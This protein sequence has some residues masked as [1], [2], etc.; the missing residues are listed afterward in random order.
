MR[1]LLCSTFATENRLY[2]KVPMSSSPSIPHAS[3]LK[4]TH[5]LWNIE[6]EHS[7]SFKKFLNDEKISNDSVNNNIINPKK[8]FDSHGSGAIKADPNFRQSQ[9]FQLYLKGLNS[10][11]LDSELRRKEAYCKLCNILFYSK[12]FL[13][14]HIAKTHN[15]KQEVNGRNRHASPTSL[16]SRD[17]Q[18]STGEYQCELQNKEQSHTSSL[19]AHKLNNHLIKTISSEVYGNSGRTNLKSDKDLNSQ[20]FL[21]QGKSLVENNESVT[22]GVP[23]KDSFFSLNWLNKLP[24]EIIKDV[25]PQGYCEQCGVY[26]SSRYYLKLHTAQKHG[27]NVTDVGFKSG[28]FKTDNLRISPIEAVSD[29]KTLG[30]T[31]ATSVGIIENLV[32]STSR[33]LPFSVSSL[34]K[35]G[36]VKSHFEEFGQLGDKDH[37]NDY[38]PHSKQANEHGTNSSTTRDNNVGGV[39]TPRKSTLGDVYNAQHPSSRNTIYTALKVTVVSPT[40]SLNFDTTQSCTKVQK[41]YKGNHNFYCDLCQKAFSNKYYLIRHRYDHHPDYVD[42]M[43]RSNQHEPFKNNKL[44]PKSPPQNVSL[45]GHVSKTP[46]PQLVENALQQESAKKYE[47]FN[48]SNFNGK[49]STEDPTG[50]SLQNIPALIPISD[51]NRNYLKD[52]ATSQ[53]LIKST[54]RNSDRFCEICNKA[55]YSRYFLR[56]HKLKAHGIGSPDLTPNKVCTSSLQKI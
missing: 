46:S 3:P 27:N 18:S 32:P 49:Y 12:Y 31:G 16:S 43:I 44:K 54:E 8:S 24:E 41:Q 51:S 13:E 33:V 22:P 26:F 40:L 20:N 5:N 17:S 29:V 28:T 15:L 38:P 2:L 6:F 25:N 1:Y 35:V 39:Q 34:S 4:N 47:V 11:Y 21:V 14:C 37:T 10:T 56:V 42:S 53:R 48:Q 55:F 36:C 30:S 23:S 9:D 50:F 52:I 7:A 19:Q 45:Q